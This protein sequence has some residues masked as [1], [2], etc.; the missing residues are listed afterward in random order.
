MLGVEIAANYPPD[1]FL[2]VRTSGPHRVQIITGP[3]TQLLVS[4]R[5]ARR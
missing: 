2:T 3:Q 5:D 4:W 1:E